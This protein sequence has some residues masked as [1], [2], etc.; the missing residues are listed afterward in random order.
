MLIVSRVRQNRLERFESPWGYFF[1]ASS[2]LSCL[3]TGTVAPI[4]LISSC[5]TSQDGPRTG[6]RRRRLAH[7][8]IIEVSWN[9]EK[10]EI[11]KD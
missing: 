8:T 9:G 1:C 5:E 3:V 11:G 6:S 10:E 4:R 2:A 7:D